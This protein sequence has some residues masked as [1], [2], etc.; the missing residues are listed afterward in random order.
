VNFQCSR[1]YEILLNEQT[2]SPNTITLTLK[3]NIEKQ[4]LVM[5]KS[6]ERFHLITHVYDAMFLLMLLFN[7]H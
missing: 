5:L 7:S 2:Y 6:I 3:Y 4:W 1:V